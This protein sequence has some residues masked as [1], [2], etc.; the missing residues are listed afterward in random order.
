M[1]RERWLVLGLWMRWFERLGEKSMTESLLF[2]LVGG[3]G[4]A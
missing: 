4:M 1:L 3:H 2:G